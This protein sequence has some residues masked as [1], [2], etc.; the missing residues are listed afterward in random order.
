ML[1]CRNKLNS[2]THCDYVFGVINSYSIH[3]KVPRA[4]QPKLFLSLSVCVWVHE[5]EHINIWTKHKHDHGITCRSLHICTVSM[6]NKCAWVIPNEQ[7]SRKWQKEKHTHTYKQWLEREMKN[8]QQIIYSHAFPCRKSKHT[9][10][11]QSVN[12]ILC[13]GYC[14]LTAEALNLIDILVRMILY[15]F[16]HKSYLN[17]LCYVCLCQLCAVIRMN[18]LK[19]VN[20]WNLT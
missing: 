8:H 5:K 7:T 16:S 14:L 3:F 4:C 17:R 9:S 20:S 12:C 13:V 15:K 6:R 11:S 10:E 18:S 2:W 1:Q 19:P